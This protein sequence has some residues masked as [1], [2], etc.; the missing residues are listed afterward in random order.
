MVSLNYYLG[1]KI[2]NHH[3][4]WMSSTLGY[5]FDLRPDEINLVSIYPALTTL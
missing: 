5:T 4:S 1:I 3:L 2:A